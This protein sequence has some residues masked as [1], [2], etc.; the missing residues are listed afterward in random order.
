[1]PGMPGLSTQQH[2]IKHVYLCSEAPNAGLRLRAHST[3]RRSCVLASQLQA[4]AGHPF[5][6]NLFLFKFINQ[7]YLVNAP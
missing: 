4:H 3:N 5:R 1:M 7:E 6:R 2:Q